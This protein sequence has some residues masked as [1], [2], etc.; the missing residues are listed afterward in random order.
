ME[1]WCTHHGLDVLVVAM[2]VFPA[3]WAVAPLVTVLLHSLLLCTGNNLNA[4][5]AV[6]AAQVHGPAAKSMKLT[7]TSYVASLWQTCKLH[8]SCKLHCT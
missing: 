8:I 1:L 5:P 2:H 3:D 4:P 6:C 7:Q